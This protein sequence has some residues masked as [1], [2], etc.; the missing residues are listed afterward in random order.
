MSTLEKPKDLDSMADD[1]EN[2]DLQRRRKGIREGKMCTHQECQEY[3]LNRPGLEHWK[4][5]RENEG[6]RR[7]ERDIQKSARWSFL[8]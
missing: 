2:I 8:K 7:V 1:V 4:P 5:A 3:I 6:K